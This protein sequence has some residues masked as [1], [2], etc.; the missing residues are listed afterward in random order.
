MKDYEVWKKQYPDKANVLAACAAAIRRVAPDAEV[1][2]YGSVARG[3]ERE[4]SD[5]DLLV[6]VPQE[7]TPALQRIVRGQIYDIALEIDQVITAIVRQR[8]LWNSEPWNY[9]PL[10]R[11]IEKEGVRL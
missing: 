7:V 5:V 1:I 2:L 11:A 8:S 6:L 4:D 10:F 3:E 9:T